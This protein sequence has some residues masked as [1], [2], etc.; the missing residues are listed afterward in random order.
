[1][2][3]PLTISDFVPY[4]ALRRQALASDP[5]SFHTTMADWNGRSLA[6][7]E[8][9]F[10]HTLNQPHNF[11]LGAWVEKQLVGMTGFE[12]YQRERI[13]H[14]G[15]IWGVYL[16]PEQR[17]RGLGSKLFDTA[18]QM[19]QEFTGLHQIQLTVMAH[20]DHALRLYQSRGF[21]IFGREK[22]AMI[23]NGRAYDELHL[24]LLF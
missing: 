18:V 13:S 20:N 7:H 3:R 22:A 1:M 4:H 9:R 11:I 23:A 16:A 6:E 10:R 19:A 17:G 12:R 8:R 24:Q 15:Y 21:E 2:L 5:L 14:K